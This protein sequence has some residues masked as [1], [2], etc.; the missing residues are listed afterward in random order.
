MKPGL[1]LTLPALLVMSGTLA[2]DLIDTTAHHKELPALPEGFEI[3]IIAREPLVRHP[4]SLAFDARG[5]LFVG[6]GPQYRNPTPDTPGDRVS[7]LTDSDGDGILDSEKIFATGL[8]CVQGL[9]WHGR[10]LWVANSPDLTVVR[11]LDGDDVADEYVRVYTDLGNIEHALHGLN[12]APDGKL[13][14][15][16][17]NSKG[18]NDPAQPG[19]VAPKP[20]REL[21]GVPSPPG[22]PDFPEPQIF[23]AADYRHAYQDPKDDW[24]QTGGVLRCDDMGKN[25]EI[26]ARGLRNPWDITLDSGF[27]WLGT[28]NDQNE[29]DRLFMPFLGAHYGWGH[30]WSA[31][32]DRPRPSAHSAGQRPRVRGFGHGPGLRRLAAVPGFA[33]PRILHQ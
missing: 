5:R 15:S 25:L 1:P 12:W 10:D 9:A 13:Y 16:K 8:N 33:S 19:R 23:K 6:M 27:N 24:G 11:D 14:M 18:L 7:M 17:G 28:D 4:C 21:W 31:R 22:A 30:A 26:V 2:A 3:R 29:G 20:F 32:L